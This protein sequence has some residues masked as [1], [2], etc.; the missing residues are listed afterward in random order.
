MDIEEIKARLRERG[1]PVDGK[2]EETE[3]KSKV[4]SPIIENQKESLG[5]IGTLLEQ[6]LEQDQQRV[7]DL[8]VALQRLKHGGGG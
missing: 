1:I 3:A 2:W 4:E 6:Q 7:A 8:H 5:K